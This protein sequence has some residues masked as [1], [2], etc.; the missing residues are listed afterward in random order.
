[1]NN[2][3]TKFLIAFLFLIGVS[4]SDNSKGP[5][6]DGFGEI[7]LTVT[8][9]VEAERTGIADFH[10]LDQGSIKSWE[11]HGNDVSPQTFSLSMSHI[12]TDPIER[13]GTGSY[14]ITYPVAQIPG[15]DPGPMTFSPAYTHIENGDFTSAVEYSYVICADDF[16]GG[17]TLNITSSSDEEISG[18][19]QFTAHNV[20]VDDMGNCILNGTVHVNGSFDALP[21]Q[22]L[23]R[24][25]Q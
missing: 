11:I 15:E 18:T 13:P 19:F 24:W 9:D 23:S 5:D 16:P 22:T 7:T 8:G 2:I 1:M 14:E 17:G 10:G 21:R 12:S 4:C 20:D 3:Y 6:T 25:S